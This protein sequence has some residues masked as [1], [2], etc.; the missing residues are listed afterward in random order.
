MIEITIDG[1]KVEVEEG[2]NLL[3]ACREQG[4]D[5]PTLCCHP[6]L[7]PYGVCRLCLVE[8]IKKG[9]PRMVASCTYPVQDEI[10]VNTGTEEVLNAR[11]M[12]ME[13][14]LARCPGS[15]KIRELADKMGVKETRFLKQDDDC[16]LCGLCVNVCEKI[17]GRSAISFV[18]R[19]TK[20][21]VSTPFNEASSDCIG[22]GACAMVCPTGAI[23]IED[24]ENVRRMIN[25]KTEL[26]LAKCA[27]CGRHFGPVA[28]LEILKER[29][30]LPED[31]L[32]LCPDCRKASLPKIA[33]SISNP[34][35][36]D[37][38]NILKTS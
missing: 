7:P 16:I 22:C 9:W 30:G 15:P 21:E 17:I 24:I 27:H 36:S 5:I 3:E 1:K 14:L 18:Y 6:A 37:L 25:W 20:R 4:I 29:S 13:L 23:K 8:V 34:E 10:E 31:I 26:P 33:S 11:K 12:I 35:I 2:K 38:V 28:E 32:N 19:G